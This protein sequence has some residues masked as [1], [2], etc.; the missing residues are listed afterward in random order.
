MIGGQG[1]SYGQE[2]AKC[3]RRKR[4]SQGGEFGH[5]R[6]DLPQIVPTS[7]ACITEARDLRGCYNPPGPTFIS[8]AECRGVSPISFSRVWR[9]SVSWV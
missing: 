1:T 4:G 3:L 2:F 5:F 9:G 7:S 6:S 8:C